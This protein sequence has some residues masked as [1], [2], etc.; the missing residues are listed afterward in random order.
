M[1]EGGEVCVVATGNARGAETC[2]LATGNETGAMAMG[3]ETG[4]ATISEAATALSNETGAGAFPPR[5]LGARHIA[6]RDGF[7]R[8]PFHAAAATGNAAALRA[9]LR[10]VPAEQAKALARLRDLSGSEAADLACRWGAEEGGEAAEL[11]GAPCV[12]AGEGDGGGEGEVGGKGEKDG[13]WWVGAAAARAAGAEEG[14]EAA[15]AGWRAEGSAESSRTEGAAVSH[16]VG[17][18]ELSFAEGAVASRV[19]AVVTSRAEGAASRCVIEAVSASISPTEFRARFFQGGRPAVL[20]GAALAAP[21]SAT[22]T[23]AA[24]LD[25]NA[26]ASSRVQPLGLPY[27][28][29]FGACAGG[30]G[31]KDM[32]LREFVEGV[33]GG[34]GASDMVGEGVG[35]F[36]AVG[37]GVGAGNAVGAAIGVDARDGAAAEVSARNGAATTDTGA[38]P[39]TLGVATGATA[40]AYVFHTPRLARDA[41]A[42]FPEGMGELPPFLRLDERVVEGNRTLRRQHVALLKSGVSGE[43]RLAVPSDRELSASEEARGAVAADAEMAVGEARVVESVGGVEGADAD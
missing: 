19:E 5:W 16:A 7:S 25:N 13:G 23:R 27:E 29:R 34:E 6:A 42:L 14:G 12:A 8:T 21:Q 38:Q 37:A 9:M 40:R 30:E 41:L 20:R 1:G 26:T 11:L 43:Q 15:A 36:D 24:L 2:A 18:A 35:A 28:C 17:A 22:W 10:A 3:N 33:M 32:T 4:T 39:Q 31:A